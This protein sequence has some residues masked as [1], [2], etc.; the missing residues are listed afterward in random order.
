[1]N[2]LIRFYVGTY[3]TKL[4]HVDGKAD[5]IYLYHMDLTNGE[6][7]FLTKEDSGPNPSF[8][9]IHPTGKY[10]YA[11]NELMEFKGIRGGGISS[12]DINPETGELSRINQQPTHGGAPCHVCIDATGQ[13]ACVANYMGGNL[14]IFPI[15]VDGSLK[16]ASDLIQHVGTSKD[17]RRQEG[18]HAHSITIDPANR[19]AFAADLGIDKV[20]SYRIDLKNG[21]FITS[22]VPWV[23]VQPGA[24]P[25]HFA[26]HP[27]GKFAYLINELDSTLNA[28]KYESEQG[29]LIELQSVPTLP[30]GF[31]GWNA[32]ADLHIL[33]SGKFIYGSNRGHDSIVI[34]SIHPESGTLEYVGHQSTQGKIPRNFAIDPTGR[35]LLVANQDTDSI[36][37]FRIDPEKGILQYTGKTIQ[38]PTPVCITFYTLK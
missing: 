37:V 34:F 1:M 13:Y 38:I 11:V 2:N 35:F 20:L 25:R 23:A 29:I 16:E 28:Y 14:T 26:F 8:L 17:P 15:D 4:G 27:N 3:T 9:A 30:E 33:P 22:D 24:G 31:T 32:C 12:F 18:P 6:I 21:K 10:L 36:V 19:Y 7:Q 5:G